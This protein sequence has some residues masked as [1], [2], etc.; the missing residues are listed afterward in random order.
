[1]TFSIKYRSTLSVKGGWMKGGGFILEIQNMPW[2][3]AFGC[4]FA[5]FCSTAKCTRLASGHSLVFQ[6]LTYTKELNILITSV[7]TVCRLLVC[8]CVSSFW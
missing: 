3:V 2:S 8:P 4:G 5:N 6:P 7:R 1:M